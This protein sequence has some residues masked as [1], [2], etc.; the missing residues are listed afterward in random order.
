MKRINGPSHP[1]TTV[2]MKGLLPLSLARTWHLL[3]LHYDERSI[4]AIHPWIIAGRTVRDEGETSYRDLRFP[5][6]RAIDRELRLRGRSVPVTWTGRVDPPDWFEYRFQSGDGTTTGI[7]RNTYR[8]S[9]DGTAV[10]T[11]ADVSVHGTPAF[12]VRWFVRKLLAR[13]DREDLAYLT[14]IDARPKG[15]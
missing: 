15:T 5:R 4:T 11:K 2:R 8:E 1:M 13:A 14:R 10:S 3:W 12:I 9:G 6:I 7:F